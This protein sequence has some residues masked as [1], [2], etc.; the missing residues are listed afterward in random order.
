MPHYSHHF[1]DN[2][3]E[4]SMNTA[5][6]LSHFISF[7]FF[8]VL[9][10]RLHLIEL[11]IQKQ[12]DVDDDFEYALDAAEEGDADAQFSLGY[13]YYEGEGVS[14]DNKEAVK[15][16]RLSAEQGDADAQFNLGVMYDQGEGVPQDNKEVVKWWR[17]AAE[18][19]HADA[20]LSLGYMYYEGEGVS[21]DNK[22]AVK[23][24][25]LSAE[26]RNERAQFNLSLM[27]DDS[28]DYLNSPN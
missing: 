8:I 10:F 6:L 25:R 9:Y 18:Q 16:W 27:H 22:E 21:Q 3:S 28:L 14:Q 19:G 1:F 26:Q 20:Q 4:E 5:A 17:L 2:A 13:M 12:D 11:L 15:W 24:W 7:I 23:W